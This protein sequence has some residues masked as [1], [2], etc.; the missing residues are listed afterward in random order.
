MTYLITDKKD[1]KAY[2][3]YLEKK[4][5]GACVFWRKNYAI[6]NRCYLQGCHETKKELWRMRILGACIFLKFFGGKNN[7]LTVVIGGKTSRKK[8]MTFNLLSTE[9]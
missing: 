5:G 9:L 2:I 8:K 6:L 4:K 1:I 3:F 7:F